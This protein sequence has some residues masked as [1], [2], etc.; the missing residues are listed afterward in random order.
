MGCKARGQRVQVASLLRVLLLE[1]HDQREWLDALSPVI[2]E[3]STVL[4]HL[5][6][7]QPDTFAAAVELLTALAKQLVGSG[8]ARVFSQLAADQ[9]VAVE[10]QT[11]FHLLA[12][13]ASDLSLIHI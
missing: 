11:L 2:V 6:S 13:T 7:R 5:A 4:A 9:R 10:A 1:A 3:C 12:A 8:A